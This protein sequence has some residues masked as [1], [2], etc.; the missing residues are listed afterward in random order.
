MA[1]LALRLAQC[2]R[3]RTAHPCPSSHADGK[4][5]LARL[6]HHARVLGAPCCLQCMF[7]PVPAGSGGSCWGAQR[8][9]KDGEAD[10]TTTALTRVQHAPHDAMPVYS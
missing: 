4:R 10:S 9:D 2:M 5:M 3:A 8:K 1:V 7:A 6:D